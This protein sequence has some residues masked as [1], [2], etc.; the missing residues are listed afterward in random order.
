M[1]PKKPPP[2]ETYILIIF[3]L[4]LSL[5]GIY[6]G[7]DLIVDSSGEHLHLNCQE[8]INYPFRDFMLPGIVV[9]ALFGVMPLLLIMPLLKKPKI[10]WLDVFNIYPKRHWAWSFSV[11]LGIFLIIWTDIQIWMIG[12]HSFLQILPS[13]YGVSIIFLCLLPDQLH[14]YSRWKIV[15]QIPRKFENDDSY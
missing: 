10:D 14:F 8:L 11:Y 13:L 2:L 7:I 12:Y 5:F 4:F 9:L 6:G 1:N 3:L 15:T